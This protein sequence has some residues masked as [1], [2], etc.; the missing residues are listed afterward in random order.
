MEL[1][2]IIFLVVHF[3]GLFAEYYGGTVFNLDQTNGFIYH[4][5]RVAGYTADVIATIDLNNQ[6]VSFSQLTN[7]RHV[8]NLANTYFP[9]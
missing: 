6:S 8:Y 5:F 2:Y 4:V 7:L 1:S 9:V 3:E